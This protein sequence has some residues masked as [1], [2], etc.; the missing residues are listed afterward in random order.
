MYRT[1]EPTSGSPSFTTE[2]PHWLPPSQPSLWR[3]TSLQHIQTGNKP[4]SSTLLLYEFNFSHTSTT[5]NYG[6]C[7]SPDLQQSVGK[8]SCS[9]GKAQG[10]RM[11]K[12]G[13]SKATIRQTQGRADARAS[14]DHAQKTL[15]G[16]YFQLQHDEPRHK[17]YDIQ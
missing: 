4:T 11:A 8:G 1:E 12:H 5:N 7:L 13:S 15:P 10:K 14:T 9:S 6:S 17:A 3:F 2:V 16:R